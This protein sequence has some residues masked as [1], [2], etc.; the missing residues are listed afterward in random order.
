M[1]KDKQ[2][3]LKLV[4]FRIFMKEFLRKPPP[5]RL[6]AKN[7]NSRYCLIPKYM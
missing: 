3:L 6:R 4:N 5:Q 2:N 1:E 7:K